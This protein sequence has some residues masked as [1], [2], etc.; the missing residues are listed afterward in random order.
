[1]R[2]T[3]QWL[4]SVS[5]AAIENGEMDNVLQDII[6]VVDL[7]KEFPINIENPKERD[8]DLYH[9]LLLS[10]AYERKRKLTIKVA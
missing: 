10:A 8:I 2:P 7:L 4:H 1:M 3:S 5:L 9:T 6:D